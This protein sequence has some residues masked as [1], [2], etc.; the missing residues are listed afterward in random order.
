MGTEFETKEPPTFEILAIGTAAI[1]RVDVIKDNA[2]VYTAA[3]NQREVSMSFT[4]KDVEPGEHYYYI[5]VLQEDEEIAWGNLAPIELD[6]AD[7]G[8]I[9]VRRVLRQAVS[10]ITGRA[11]V[12]LGGHAAIVRA[13]SDEGSPLWRPP[14]G[15]R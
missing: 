5:R 12:R 6:R 8:Q 4:D 15:C 7:G 11:V 1:A 10:P 9:G 14:A 13:A 3:P 2:I